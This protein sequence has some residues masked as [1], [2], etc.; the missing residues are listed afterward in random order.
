MMTCEEFQF[1]AQCKA[2]SLPR[3]GPGVNPEGFTSSEELSPGPSPADPTPP[4]S[5]S[6]NSNYYKIRMGK[7]GL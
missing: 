2:R 1:V 5:Q 7:M 4:I 3:S 6:L